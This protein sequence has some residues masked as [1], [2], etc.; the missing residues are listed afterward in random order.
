MI[1]K[2]RNK[3]TPANIYLFK[4]N[5]INLRISCEACSKFKVKTLERRY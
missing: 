3:S 2:Y 5:N 4:V 1:H